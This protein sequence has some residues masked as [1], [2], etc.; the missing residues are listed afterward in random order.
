MKMSGIMQ[1]LNMSENGIHRL[2]GVFCQKKKTI[3][4]FNSS[5]LELNRHYRPMIVKHKM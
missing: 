4:T 2:C 5:K 1:N 3:L